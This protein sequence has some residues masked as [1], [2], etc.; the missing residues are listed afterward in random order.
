MELGGRQKSEKQA[1]QFS[2]CTQIVMISKSVGAPGSTEVMYL[3]LTYSIAIMTKDIIV[4]NCNFLVS[5]ILA[6]S[7]LNNAE[8]VESCE[9][10]LYKS[11]NLGRRLLAL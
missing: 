1:L 3:S 7:R 6:Q 4:W 10:Q 9:L 5:N 2:L 8:N 11:S